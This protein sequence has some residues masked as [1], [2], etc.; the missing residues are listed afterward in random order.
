MENTNKPKDIV[1]ENGVERELG[2]EEKESIVSSPSK[3]LVEK[4]ITPEGNQ[5]HVVKERV[6]G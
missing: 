5:K 6:T 4:E 2:A 1:V 3:K